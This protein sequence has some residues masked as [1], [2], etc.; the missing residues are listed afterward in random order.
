MLIGSVPESLDQESP[1]RVSR[2]TRRRLVTG[3]EMK[4]ELVAF[5]AM[6]ASFLA[7]G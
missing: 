2:S 3:P 4:A 6:Q 5:S 1:E 7:I